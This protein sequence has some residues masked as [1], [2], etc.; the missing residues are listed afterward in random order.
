MALLGIWSS[1]QARLHTS[2]PPHQGYNSSQSTVCAIWLIFT[3]WFVNTFKAKVPALQFPVIIFSIVTIVAFAYGPI[4]TTVA[5]MNAFVKEL[6]IAF[7]TAFGI[8]TG[9]N[10]FIIPVSSRAVVFSEFDTLDRMWVRR[11]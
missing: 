9:V 4:F 2:A 6:L 10:L 5:A 1:L 8:A 7:L 3:I 11:R